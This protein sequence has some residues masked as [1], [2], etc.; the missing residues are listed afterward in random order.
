MATVKRRDDKNRVLREGEAQRKNGTYEYKWR[1]K[2]GKRRGIYAKTLTELREKEEEVKRDALDGIRTAKKSLTINDLFV[3][4]KQV[5]RGLKD[6][7]FQNYCYLYDAFVKPDFGSMKVT[8][9]KKTDVRAFYN[10]LADG[11]GLK[12]NTIDDVHTVLHQVLELA[13]EDDYLR[14]NPSDRALV[15]LK[16]AHNHNVPRRRALTVKEQELF[17]DFIG[18]RPCYMHWK[19]IFTVMLWTG[20]RVGEA[21]GLR[22]CDIDLEKGTININHTLVYY[23]KD[24]GIHRCCSFSINSPKTRAGGRTIPMLPVVRQAFEE[25]KKYQ[26]DAGIECNCRIDGYTDFIF[27][28][29]FGKTHNESTL[30]RALKRIIRDCNYDVMDHIK[31]GNI[32]E[33]VT[34]PPFS[35]HIL[36]HTFTTRMCEAGVNIKAMQD[37]LGHADAETTM[38]IYADATSDLKELE[39]KNFGQFFSSMKRKREAVPDDET[40]DQAYDR[41]VEYTTTYD[42]IYDQYTTSGIDM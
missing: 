3:L 33:A 29:R 25:E 21:T 18:R 32:E 30:N 4:W 35:N 17:E 36:R 22:W 10:R 20:M 27:L 39:M 23:A 38:N 19:P 13:V 41:M 12:V 28:N 7:T 15:E 40:Y 9:I 2:T 16:R 1:D 42:R 31:D 14:N 8:D 34:L 11:R 5:K 37:I 24:D 6:N 26:E